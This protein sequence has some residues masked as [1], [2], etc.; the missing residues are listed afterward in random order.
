M[1]SLVSFILTVKFWHALCVWTLELYVPLNC[2]VNFSVDATVDL[3]GPVL[4]DD[5]F[6]EIDLKIRDIQQEVLIRLL[7]VNLL[8]PGSVLLR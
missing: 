5:V 4:S 1:P 7:K 6:I 8:L 2:N 3:G